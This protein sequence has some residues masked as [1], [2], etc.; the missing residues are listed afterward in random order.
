MKAR[1]LRPN[2]SPRGCVETQSPGTSV[3][4]TSTPTKNVTWRDAL[5]PRRLP[6]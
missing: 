2:P 3:P 1:S 5:F 6:I 4:R